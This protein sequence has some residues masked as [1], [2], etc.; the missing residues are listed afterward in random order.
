MDDNT[1]YIKVTSVVSP[2]GYVV[3]T[4]PKPWVSE[5]GNL[6]IGDPPQVLIHA[7]RWIAVCII[8]PDTG[9]PIDVITPYSSEIKNPQQDRSRRGL[10]GRR[11]R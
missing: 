9:D 7:G 6:G 2:W 4:G 10:F 3:A 1:Y 11:R 8:D 5:Q